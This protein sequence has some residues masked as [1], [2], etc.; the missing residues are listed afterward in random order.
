MTSI[1]KGAPMY[2]EDGK[3][4]TIQEFPRNLDGLSVKDLEEYIQDLQ[5]EIAR[6]EA[7]KE[8]KKTSQSE[9]DSFFKS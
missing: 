5:N 2:T 8:K 3:K 6:V 9:A 4:I 1:F 7:N